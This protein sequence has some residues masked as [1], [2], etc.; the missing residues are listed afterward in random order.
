M[1][2]NS[3]RFQK[4]SS[5]LTRV[6]HVLEKSYFTFA[7]NVFF[8]KEVKGAILSQNHRRSQGGGPWGPSP[9]N[10]NAT[11]VKSL[12]KKPGFFIFSFF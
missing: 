8:M 7:L 6:L 11:N 1:S 3:W 12:T 10:R 5:D 2:C 4:L 9:L